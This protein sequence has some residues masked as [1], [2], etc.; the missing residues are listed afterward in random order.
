MEY[1]GEET[2]SI[3]GENVTLSTMKLVDLDTEC[4]NSLAVRANTKSF[5]QA[6]KRQPVSYSEVR[7]WVNSLIQGTEKAPAAT[8][9]VPVHA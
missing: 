1:L 9:A 8:G 7:L 4:W 6:M 2:F 5:I 3:S